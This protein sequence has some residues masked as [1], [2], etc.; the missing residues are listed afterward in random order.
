MT[1]TLVKSVLKINISPKQHGF[2]PGRSVFTNFLELSNQVTEAFQ[3]GVQID[4]VYFDLKKAFDSVDHC[5]L[6]DK[7]RRFGIQGSILQWFKSYLTDWSQVVSVSGNTLFPIN[8]TSGIAQ[9]SRLGPLLFA[10]FINDLYD[11]V[12]HSN[13]HLFADDSRL[14]KTITSFQDARLT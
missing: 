3:Q 1:Y 12:K 7:L 2:I 11:V 14:S 10:V 4:V 9:G 8:V 5:L 6:I 13:L